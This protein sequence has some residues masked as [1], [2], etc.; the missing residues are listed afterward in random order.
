MPRCRIC[1]DLY[2]R[3]EEGNAWPGVGEILDLRTLEK[4]AQNGCFTCSLLREGI[5]HCVPKSVQ[6]EHVLF[7]IGEGGVHSERLRPFLSINV[8]I[9]AEYGA[10]VEFFRS[11]GM[12]TLSL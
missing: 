10:E 5:I 12:Y 6:M 2:E 7:R 4:S 11:V 1:N 3:D 9:G 8:G